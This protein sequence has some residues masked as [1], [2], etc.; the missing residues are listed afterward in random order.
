MKTISEGLIAKNITKAIKQSSKS[1]KTI[2]IES[3]LSETGLINYAKGRRTP[4]VIVLEK[5]A[6]SCGKE[7]S[8]LLIDHDNFPEAWTAV[9]NFNVVNEE[10][11]VYDIA[12]IHSIKDVEWIRMLGKV[13]AGFPEV[14]ENDFIDEIPMTR[15]RLPK[16][17]FALEVKG[18]SM[19]TKFSDGDII[20]FCIDMVNPKPGQF[21]VALDEFGGS[22]IKQ[23]QLKDDEVWLVSLNPVYK[24]FKANEHYRI[25]GTVVGKSNF[26]K[27]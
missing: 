26:E 22:M 16:N 3:D 8:W 13:P 21:V 1:Q 4:D 18:D 10:R 25:L 20:F 5:I 9:E 27:Y 11:S 24:P 6:R 14:S 7:L 23:Y 15:G 12:R 17:T 2:A 19:I